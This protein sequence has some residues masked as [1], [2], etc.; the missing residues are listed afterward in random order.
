MITLHGVSKSFGQ[1]LLFQDASLQINKG[2][3]YVLVGPNG[4]GKSTLFKILLGV[5]ESD[6]G[7]FTIKRGS[8]VRVLRDNVVLHQG[9]LDSLKRFK[10]DVREVKTGFECGLSLKNFNDIEVGD[11][12]EVFEVVEVARTL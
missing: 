8:S 5:E 9:E 12:L 4:S 7:Q 2:D 1:Q 11:R 3:R 6:A 10:D